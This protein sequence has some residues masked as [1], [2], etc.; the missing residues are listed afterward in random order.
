MGLKAKNG[1]IESALKEARPFWAPLR[2]K[3]FPLN[4]Q[5]HGTFH[6]VLTPSQTGRKLRMRFS[7]S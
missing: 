4:P 1:P 2:F 3:Q 6:R 5:R 7:F